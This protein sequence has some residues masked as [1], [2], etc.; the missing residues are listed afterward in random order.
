[1]VEC[2]AEVGI[3]TTGSKAVG[4]ITHIRPSGQSAAQQQGVDTPPAARKRKNSLG[5]SSHGSGLLLSQQSGGLNPQDAMPVPDIIGIPAPVLLDPND[6]YSSRQPTKDA[7]AAKPTTFTGVWREVQGPMKGTF[8]AKQSGPTG[9]RITPNI[10]L[11]RP[12]H[13]LCLCVCV[14]QPLSSC[15]PHTP[16]CHVCTAGCDVYACGTHNCVHV[17]TVADHWLLC[18]P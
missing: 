10:Y 12:Y 8:S 13:G 3:T 5:L 6:K 16:D 18:Y 14:C 15:P 9:Q 1:M 17:L 2:A 7:A 11:V 4:H